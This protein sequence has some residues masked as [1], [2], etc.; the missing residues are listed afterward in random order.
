LS[1]G[2]RGCGGGPASEISEFR[3]FTISLPPPGVEQLVMVVVVMV[4]VVMK[5]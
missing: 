5:L 1:G 4:M 2:S 3:N